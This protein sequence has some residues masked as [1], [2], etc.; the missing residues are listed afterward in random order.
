MQQCTVRPEPQVS[1]CSSADSWYSPPQFATVKPNGEV[2]SSLS[3]GTSSQGEQAKSPRRNE[4]ARAEWSSQLSPSRRKGDGGGA[5]D[6]AKL[7]PRRRGLFPPA[8][9]VLDK[10]KAPSRGRGESGASTRKQARRGILTA[11]FR[12]QLYPVSGKGNPRRGSPGLSGSWGT[13]CRDDDR[14]SVPRE[15]SAPEIGRSLVTDGQC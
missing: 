8:Y 6:V 7:T 12:D 14:Q 11:S 3:N 5:E 10:A 4:M 1:A 13:D 2:I 15:N 9:P